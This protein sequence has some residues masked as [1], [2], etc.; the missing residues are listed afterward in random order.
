MISQGPARSCDRRLKLRDEHTGLMAK[1][2][3]LLHYLIHLPVGLRSGLEDVLLTLRVRR[4]QLAVSRGHD[5]PSPSCTLA[6]TRATRVANRC[7]CS[8]PHSPSSRIC[9]TPPRLCSHR[10]P[11]GPSTHYSRRPQ[12]VSPFQPG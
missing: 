5:S 3:A 1:H 9:R 8:G 6:G 7:A 2:P 12:A 10:V 4:V 11:G